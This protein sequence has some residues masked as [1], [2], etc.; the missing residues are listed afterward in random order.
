MTPL[1]GLYRTCCSSFSG[2]VAFL[3]EKLITSD[4]I[5]DSKVRADLSAICFEEEDI[6]YENV[7]TLLCIKG[8][9]LKKN[10]RYKRHTITWVR[11]HR[12]TMQTASKQ[13]QRMFQ[14][15]LGQATS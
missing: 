14:N 4:P 1:R 7:S 8:Q 9:F 5:E 3:Q 2:I 13:R 10:N 12:V 11:E 6:L 15:K